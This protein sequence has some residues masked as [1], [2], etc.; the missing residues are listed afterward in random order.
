MLT[1][2]EIKW[3]GK[4]LAL[5]QPLE[6][7]NT[8]REFHASNASIRWFFGGNQCLRMCQK[9]LMADG[10]TKTISD[11]SIG[12]VVLGYDIQTGISTPV[13]VLNV[14]Q[15]GIKAMYRTTF[16]DGDFVVSTLKSASRPRFS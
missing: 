4:E 9:I 3:L 12:D 1:T 16:N 13:N 5:Y 7:D 8:Q 11:V 6:N 14:Y 2:T 10:S 15:N